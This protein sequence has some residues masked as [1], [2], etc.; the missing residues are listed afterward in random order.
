MI[1]TI[2]TI[3]D[4]APHT[5][6]EIFKTIKDTGYSTEIDHYSVDK[7]DPGQGEFEAEMIYHKHADSEKIAV[8]TLRIIDNKKL[9][10]LYRIR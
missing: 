6:E 3:A 8:M 5:L 2:E 10:G 9:Y 4:E 1:K 7:I